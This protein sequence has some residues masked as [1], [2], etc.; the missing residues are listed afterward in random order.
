MLPYGVAQNRHPSRCRLIVVRR[1]IATD[2]RMK[3]KRRKEVGRDPIAKDPI[4]LFHAGDVEQSM[5]ESGDR[6]TAS[7]LLLETKKIGRS[8]A[9]A[10][11]D[12][13]PI[14]LPEDDELP[15]VGIG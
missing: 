12:I 9:T 8:N 3:A 10:L 5:S 7:N 1:E 13:I 4:G 6:L 15:R 2:R 11:R 14:G